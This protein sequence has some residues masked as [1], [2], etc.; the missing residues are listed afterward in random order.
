MIKLSGYEASALAF[1]ARFRREPEAASTAHELTG[2]A[3]AIADNILLGGNSDPTAVAI[4][5]W[6]GDPVTA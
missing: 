1:V 2:V 4:L 5:K 6:A 3:R